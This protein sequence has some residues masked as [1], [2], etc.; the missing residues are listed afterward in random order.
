MNKVIF[1]I[2]FKAQVGSNATHKTI[3]KNLKILDLVFLE[4]VT[5]Y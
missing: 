2:I 1:L 3:F 5:K 4:I